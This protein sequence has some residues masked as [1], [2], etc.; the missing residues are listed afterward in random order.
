M[1][2]DALLNISM[3]RKQHHLGGFQCRVHVINVTN[4]FVVLHS[5]QRAWDGFL[6]YG[7][8]YLVAFF[9]G[10]L[11]IFELCVLGEDQCNWGPLT[12]LYNIQESLHFDNE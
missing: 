11:L 1:M 9:I 3:S 12:L 5:L 8:C 10:A 4:S 7:G 6:R 2:S